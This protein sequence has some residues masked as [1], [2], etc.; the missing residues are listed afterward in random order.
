MSSADSSFLLICLKQAATTVYIGAIFLE[1]K[2]L[3]FLRRKGRI[4]DKKKGLSET[5]YPFSL[6]QFIHQRKQNT[7]ASK[8]WNVGIIGYGL[9]AKIFHIP[10]VNAVPDFKLYAIVQRSPKPNDD[11]EK[12]WPGVKSYRSTEELVKDEGVDVV[13]VTTAPDSHVALTKQAL[14]AG[15]HGMLSNAP[16]LLL[17]TLKGQFY[18]RGYG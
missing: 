14:E 16:G 18:E 15:K 5:R 13:I 2:S 1:Y 12:D 8:I 6:I 3:R 17:V 4:Q 10:F 7:M 11:A 9:S